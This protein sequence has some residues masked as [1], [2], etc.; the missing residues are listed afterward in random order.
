MNEKEFQD[1]LNGLLD[2]LQK[3]DNYTLSSAEQDKLLRAANYLKRGGNFG[4]AS[5]D[6]I[7]NIFNIALQG[8][9]N[10]ESF[11]DRL[12]RRQKRGELAEELSSGFNVIKDLAGLTASMGQIRQSNRTLRGLSR[13]GM[14][15]PPSEDPQ[16]QQAI[17]QASQGTMNAANQV[18]P[19]I[20]G[21][22][23]QYAQDLGL[24]RDISGGQSSTYGALGQLASL[25]RTRGLNE[26]APIIDNIRAREQARLDDLLAR[27]QGFR[28]QDFQNR[29]GLSEMA[30]NQY[31]KEASAAGL[32]GQIGRENLFSTYGNLADDLSVLGANYYYN[33]SFTGNQD[34]DN[35]SSRIDSNLA[36]LNK[37]YSRL[38]GRAKNRHGLDFPI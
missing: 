3:E 11:L 8:A 19:V 1:F 17:Y 38:P 32:Q 31:N 12:E 4:M 33:K 5:A 21:L 20:E 25:R 37:P 24:A 6:E 26:A 2:K 27:R 18:Q 9:S 23:Q 16:L 13:P 10:K 34:I 35:Y 30:L 29:L 15:T 28:Q 14:P 36:N 22:N 7:S